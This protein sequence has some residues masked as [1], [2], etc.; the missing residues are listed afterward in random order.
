MNYVNSFFR[1]DELEFREL[2][3]FLSRFPL[4]R[5]S[6]EL[7]YS[8]IARVK[9]R[10]RK[11]RRERVVLSRRL[12]LQRQFPCYRGNH[13]VVLN[14]RLIAI[15][16]WKE[17]G[18][19]FHGNFSTRPVRRWS[20]SWKRMFEVGGTSGMPCNLSRAILPAMLSGLENLGTI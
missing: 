3:I 11:R 10:R 16:Q 13:R 17:E 15:A 9:K 5:G 20:G 7:L 18:R 2:L 6:I 4:G 1:Q 12:I 8:I 14:K 19:Y